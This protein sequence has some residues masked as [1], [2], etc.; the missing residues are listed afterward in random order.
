MT[1]DATWLRIFVLEIYRPQPAQQCGGVIWRRIG[2]KNMGEPGS[3]SV[4][5][6]E[7]FRACF[8]RL[9]PVDNQMKPA[10][11][12][13]A[14]TQPGRELLQSAQDLVTRLL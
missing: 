4:G 13:V 8:Q 14:D 1:N 3:H 10:A 7:F 9:F 2:A 11:A 6:L 5:T 12:G